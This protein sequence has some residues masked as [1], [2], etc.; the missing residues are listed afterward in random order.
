MRFNYKFENKLGMKYW[1][2]QYDLMIKQKKSVYDK[3]YRERTKE[4]RKLYRD[5][6]W[7]EHKEEKKAYNKK[8]RENNK[9]YFKK[10]TICECGSEYVINKTRHE[11]TPKHQQYLIDGKVRHKGDYNTAKTICGCGGQYLSKMKKRHE[12]TKKH[13]KYL[14]SLI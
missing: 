8:F 13:Q 7:A 12:K 9:E 10:K 6:Y 5:K 1:E 14:S 11:A 2:E 4:A 3:K